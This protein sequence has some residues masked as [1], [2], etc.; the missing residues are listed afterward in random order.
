MKQLDLNSSDHVS[1]CLFS[2]N[3]KIGCSDNSIDISVALRLI[4]HLM[5][6]PGKEAY[7][8]VWQLT[9][10][11]KLENTITMNN[12]WA[13]YLPEKYANDD[14][15]FMAEAIKAK[16]KQSASM[17]AVRYSQVVRETSLMWLRIRQSEIK[18]TLN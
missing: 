1:V 13:H 10:N 16:V 18:G 8:T 3:Y 15:I 6:E 4:L 12:Q 2:N 14:A 9:K 17:T 11:H 5:K 7:P